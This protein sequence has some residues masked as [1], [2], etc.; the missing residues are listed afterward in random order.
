MAMIDIIHS[1]TG[2]EMTSAPIPSYWILEGQPTT[3]VGDITASHDG[4]LRYM[5]WDC[6][7]SRFHWYYYFDETVYIL[8]GGMTVTTDDG[9]VIH[10]KA[11]DVLFF[12]CGSHAI[13]NVEDYVRKVAVC[14]DI[15][16]IA[17]NAFWKFF[18]R[19]RF[20]LLRRRGYYDRLAA[21]AA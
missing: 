13:W 20:G 3:R 12:P 15:K 1:H 19:V 10:A 6:T 17:L 7:K 4:T 18:W 16:P 14:R 9:K 8:E 2:V 11:G 21:A 5:I